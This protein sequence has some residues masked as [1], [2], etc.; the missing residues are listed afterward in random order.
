MTNITRRSLAAA[1]LALAAAPAARAQSDWPSRAVTLVVPWVALAILQR[2]AAW[3]PA[4]LE[5][6]AFNPYDHYA[7]SPAQACGF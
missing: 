1:S 2:D 6:T 5:R 7:D 4:G 3:A